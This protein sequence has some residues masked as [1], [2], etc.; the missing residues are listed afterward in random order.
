MNK[1]GHFHIGST[2]PKFLLKIDHP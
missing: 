1:G 2:K